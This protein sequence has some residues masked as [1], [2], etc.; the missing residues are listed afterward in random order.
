MA[1]HDA[2][3]VH[4]AGSCHGRQRRLL[5]AERDGRARCAPAGLLKRRQLQRGE[6]RK[7]TQCTTVR[8]RVWLQF[9]PVHKLRHG[10]LPPPLRPQGRPHLALLLVLLR[11]A[12]QQRV[13]ERAHGVRGPR[14]AV[15]RRAGVAARHQVPQRRHP[16]AAS[17]ASSCAAY[18][19][20]VLHAPPGT[21]RQ[22]FTGKDFRV[23]GSHGEKRSNWRACWSACWS[24]PKLN[25][26]MQTA[27]AI[28]G[29]AKLTSELTKE[30][31]E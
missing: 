24:N 21:G 13:D 20:R 7:T 27:Q 1:W 29:A 22:S 19:V 30:L 25:L 26:T 17:S 31:D 11:A 4:G 3:H 14:A 5:R 9:W 12:T 2:R 28:S 6:Q 16:A 8:H 18:R 23:Q 15:V 10:C